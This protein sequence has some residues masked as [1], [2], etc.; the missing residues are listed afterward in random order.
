MPSMLNTIG[1][2]QPVGASGAQRKETS[3]SVIRIVIHKKKKNSDTFLNQVGSKV[4]DDG[5]LIG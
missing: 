4:K 3:L 1:M 2:V 5:I